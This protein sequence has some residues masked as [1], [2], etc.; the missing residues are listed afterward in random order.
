MYAY[1]PEMYPDESLYSVLARLRTHLGGLSSVQFQRWLYAGKLHPVDFELVG[2]I[3]VIAYNTYGTSQR[4]LDALI[5]DHTGLN[6]YLRHLE[7]PLAESC[8]RMYASGEE[9]GLLI[10]AGSATSNIGRVK[11]LRYC[12]KC[13]EIMR[14]SYGELYWRRAHNLPGSLVCLD[15]GCPLY[16][17]TVD[18]C[19]LGRFDFI[20][21]DMAICPARDHLVCDMPPEVIPLA[22]QL[23]RISADFLKASDCHQSRVEWAAD[24]MVKIRTLGL[25]RGTT[26]VD[27]KKLAIMV[28][29]VYSGIYPYLKDCFC[30]RRDGF[31]PILSM[32][33]Q[34]KSGF[35][36]LDHA[37][38][39][40]FLSHAG[41]P[42]TLS[43]SRIINLYE[44]EH[45]ATD[46]GYRRPCFGGVEDW[47]AIDRVLRDAVLLIADCIRSEQPP[48]RI[49]RVEVER[50]LPVGGRIGKRLQ[51]LPKTA[52]VLSRYVE[53]TQDFQSRRVRW[54]IDQFVRLGRPITAAAI[55]KVS[56]IRFIQRS[57][58][59]QLIVEFKDACAS[60]IGR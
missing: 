20:S 7:A 43:T 24:Y 12:S 30:E 27:D 25:M 41:S 37:L 52:E 5:D 60:G 50:R 29:D 13:L 31:F 21:A 51:H 14:A 47:D 17:S 54:H 34:P 23:A 26:M 28:S 36:P 40:V 6:Y 46:A 9:R 3:N 16:L 22:Q 35:H 48:V 42:R 59:E 1:F 2:G 38:M 32:L 4:D 57:R 44:A 58:I 11:A 8:R 39:E 53:T 49:S 33:R 18:L 10:W 56:G 45:H 15:H 55:M 19:R